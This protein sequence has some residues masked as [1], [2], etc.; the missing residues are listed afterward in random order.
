MLDLF[1]SFAEKLRKPEL[2]TV[3]MSLKESG[4][5][6]HPTGR[7]EN[8]LC[9]YN[10]LDLATVK[11]F[12]RDCFAHDLLCMVLSDGKTMIEI[13]EE[14]P[15]WNDFIRE[16]EQNLKPIIPVGIWWAALVR[17]PFEADL[18]TI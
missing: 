5:I 16:A 7:I 12:K 6:L 18:A 2:V 15:A 14:Q 1:H 4:F 13:N 9:S 10:W 17:P 8:P 3:S 11:V